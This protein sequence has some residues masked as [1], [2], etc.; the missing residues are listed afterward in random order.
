MIKAIKERSFDLAANTSYFITMTYN[1]KHIKV[2]RVYKKLFNKVFKGPDD[3]A[4]PIDVMN[5]YD[6]RPQILVE[7]AGN[8]A[9][10][11]MSAKQGWASNYLT[12]LSESLKRKRKAA[13][14]PYSSVDRIGEYVYKHN[15]ID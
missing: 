3:E 13:E 11:V 9:E 14:Y 4:M 6:K 5:D 10:A 12:N 7:R 8:V 15:E 2:R 1:I